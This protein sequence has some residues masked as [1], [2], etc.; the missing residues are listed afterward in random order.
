MRQCVQLG[1]T[2]ERLIVI[3]DYFIKGVN[4]AFSNLP[5]APDMAGDFSA[6]SFIVHF[7]AVVL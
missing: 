7:D 4:V 3:L 1:G 5:E 2:T 6:L